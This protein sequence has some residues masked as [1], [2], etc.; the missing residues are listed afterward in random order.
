MTYMYTRTCLPQ[1]N[2][3]VGLRLSDVGSLQWPFEEPTSTQDCG[4]HSEATLY[5]VL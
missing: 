5:S 3:Y 4:P 2:R 1:L